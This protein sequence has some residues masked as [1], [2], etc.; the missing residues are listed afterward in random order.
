MGDRRNGFWCVSAVCFEV[1]ST[2][3]FA[4]SRC[5]VFIDIVGNQSSDIIVTYL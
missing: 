4:F 2:G 5:D 3:H 1:F